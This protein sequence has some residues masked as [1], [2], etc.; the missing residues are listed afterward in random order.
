[1]EGLLSTRP[2]P[3]T[4]FEHL[5]SAFRSWPYHGTV[6]RSL[7]ACAVMPLLKNFLKGP[8]ETQSFRYRYS[9]CL[10]LFDRVILTL[11]GNLLTSG[12]VQMGYKKQSST[13][14]CSYVMMET[15]THFF[16]NGSN[17]IMVP[18]DMT[19]KFDCCCFDALFTKC[20]AILPSIVI[21][22]L[23]FISEKQ[24]A[25]VRWGNMSKSETFNI[26]N[27]TRQGSV[28]SPTLFNVYV[29]DLIDLLN[30][31]KMTPPK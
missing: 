30:K 9:L 23:I 5:A 4:F 6:T 19:S 8:A 22:A 1:M 26:S 3:S 7:L 21:R 28:L 18:L 12:S 15:V 29:Q 24:Y 16:N 25:C 2:T 13:T 11:W 31:K 10:K 27:G 14:Q 17:Q 20:E